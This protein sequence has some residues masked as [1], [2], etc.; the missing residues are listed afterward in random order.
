MAT[1]CRPADAGLAH[2]LRVELSHG[3]SPTS[4]FTESPPPTI[5]STRHADG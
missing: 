2:R 1:L 5:P 3:D 4:T